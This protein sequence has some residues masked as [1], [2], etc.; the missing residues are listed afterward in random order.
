[1]TSLICAI[2]DEAFGPSGGRWQRWGPEANE[3]ESDS[4]YQ[5]KLLRE[6]AN[7]LRVARSKILYI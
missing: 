6:L 3:D 4:D 1:M 7:L 2:W 5:K